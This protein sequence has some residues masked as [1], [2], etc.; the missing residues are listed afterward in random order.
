MKVENDPN[1]FTE[2]TI[3]ALKKK[4]NATKCSNHRTISLTAHTAKT[5]RILTGRIGRK[6]EDVLAEDQFG[7]GRE[8]GT[9][10]IGLL[11][12]SE[13]TM[14]IEEEP[15]ARARALQRLAKSICKCKLDQINA[16]PKG[17]WYR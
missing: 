7:F 6:T 17:N 13:R 2:A 16:D 8:K 4:P 1:E 15:R 9:I 12:I 14:N 10:A 11:R 3:T 5:A